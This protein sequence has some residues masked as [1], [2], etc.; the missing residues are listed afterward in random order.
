MD[1]RNIQKTGN[2]FYVYLPTAWC[3]KFG[4][5]SDSQVQLTT[6]TQGKLSV[7]ATLQ[8]KKPKHIQLTIDET[9]LEVINKLIVSCY[10]NPAGSFRIN[11]KEKLDQAKLLDQKKLVS[12]ELVEIEGKQITCEG[13]VSVSDPSMIL[14]TLVNKIKNM[15][16]V[17]NK[18][19]NKELIER[20]EEEIDRNR[21]LIDKAIISALT[22]HQPLKKSSLS[23]F[24]ISRIAKE[25]ESVADY[26]ILIDQKEKKFLDEISKKMD[27]LKK[28]L[29]LVLES[30][31]EFDYKLAIAFCKEIIA[32]KPIKIT[33][34]EMYHKHQIRASL[35]DVSE[36]LMD[37]AIT[38][39]VEE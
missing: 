19:Y 5:T 12:I 26:L 16:I 25:L 13:S 38:H 4:I 37:W 9:D 1:V 29:E 6:D 20:Y 18:N 22:F 30:S 2:M 3:K 39:E 8:E 15:L 7:S 35:M 34:V 24:Y 21:L 17:M 14:K 27:S 33:S 36:V 23:L 32:I 11:L 28:T 10:I 31:N